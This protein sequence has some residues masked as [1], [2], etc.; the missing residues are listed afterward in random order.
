MSLATA[1]STVGSE[2]TYRMLSRTLKFWEPLIY[3]LPRSPFWYE[4]YEYGSEGFRL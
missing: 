4:S 3:R 2:V 1:V